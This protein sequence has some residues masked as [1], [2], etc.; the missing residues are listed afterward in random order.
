[1][2]LATNSTLQAPIATARRFRYRLLVFPGGV[3]LN[4]QSLVR[5]K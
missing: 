5:V 4:V 3:G 1:M 2:K